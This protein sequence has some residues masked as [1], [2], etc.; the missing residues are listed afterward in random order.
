MV[1]HVQGEH[2]PEPAQPV[3]TTQAASGGKKPEKFPRPTVG[4][5]EPVRSG[6]T[7][8]QHGPSTK[9]SAAFRG[10]ASPGSCCCSTELKT[11]L[12]R[13]TGWKHFTLDKATLLLRM[14][15]LVVE[16]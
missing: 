16:Y 12:N 15:E 3:P 4:L 6:M 10:R 9:R 2:A 11:R 5:D 13:V 14:R 8:R 1:L 7:S